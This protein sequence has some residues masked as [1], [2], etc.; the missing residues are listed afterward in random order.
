MNAIIMNAIIAGPLILVAVVALV[1]THCAASGKLN[2]NGIAGIRIPSTMASDDA[3]RAG[4]RA[5][6]P[7]VWLTVPVALAGSA[8]IAMT[9]PGPRRAHDIL[10]VLV[11]V[12]TLVLIAA[13]VVAGKAARRVGKR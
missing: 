10:L 8:Y 13:A 12:L 5:A 7:I 4:H 1:T 3:W 11:A 9:N 2:R 6:I